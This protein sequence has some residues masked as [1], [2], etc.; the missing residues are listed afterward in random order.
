MWIRGNLFIPD[1]R[2]YWIKPSVKFLTEYLKENPVDAIISTGPPHSMHMIALKVHRKLKIPWI[3]DF[4]DPW[5]NIDFYHELRLSK[6]ADKK[7]R[8]MELSVLQEASRVVC[9]TWN[10]ANDL[11]NIGDRKVDVIT[12]GYDPQDF[13]NNDIVLDSEFSIT[14]IGSMNKDRNPLIL[15]T[16]LKSLCDE[17]TEFKSKLKIRLVGQVDH[18]IIEAINENGLTDN[19]EKI[20]FIPH[21]QV[22]K[23]LMSSQLLL[24]PINRTPNVGGVV[25][26]QTL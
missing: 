17:S 25:P 21:S 11:E 1:S 4:R 6:M 19:L 9:V 16:G 10:W 7:H 3:A 15:W 5:T 23:E 8:R 12:N 20:D 14:H 22:V 24:L 2:K 26:G 18:S 13:K